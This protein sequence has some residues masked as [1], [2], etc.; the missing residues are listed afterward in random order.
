VTVLDP[1]GDSVLTVVDLQK[2]GFSSHAKPHF[3]A[4]EPDGSYWY[5]S[6]V[7]DNAVV[8]LDRENRVVGKAE[9]ETPGLLALD[10]K[11]DRLFATRSMSAVRA[12][13]RIGVI[14][15]STMAIEEVEVLVPR[16]HALALSRDG[17]FAYV[18]SLGTNQIAVYDVDKDR[19]DVVD[20]RGDTNRV[21]VQFAVSPDGRTLAATAQ[22]TGELLGLDLRDQA[23]PA[24]SR[25]VQVG[26]W[27][28][29]VAWSP[30]GDEVW[31]PNQL[32]DN[33]SV[34]DARS[35]KLSRTISDSGFAQPHGIAVL[36]GRVFISNHN[37]GHTMDMGGVN[38]AMGDPDRPGHVVVVDQARHQV[39]RTL[40]IA[41]DG[42]GMG[43]GGSR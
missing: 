5:V 13:S 28:W 3:V 23:K 20:V 4:V 8:K 26:K 33:L 15:R 1:V 34:V 14:Q 24:L 38:M 35:W 9:M 19:V 31:V 10:P 41:P 30:R 22:L 18:G 16:P 21:M 12:P 36:V 2:L 40:A 42:A 43:A 27:P 32:S 25:T 29:H 7:G 17:K 11:S 37:G 6:L 39:L